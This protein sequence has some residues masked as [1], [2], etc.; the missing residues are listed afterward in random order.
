MPVLAYLITFHTYGSW[1]K[2]NVRG[3]VDRDH[4]ARGEPF[5]PPNVLQ[6]KYERGRMTGDG[7]RISPEQRFVIDHATRGVCEHRAWTLH[8]INIRTTHVHVVVTS[9]DRPEKVMGDMKAW[10]TR[11]LR[12]SGVVSAQN[13]MW[14]RHGSTRYLWDEVSVERAVDY[15][16]RRQGAPLPMREIQ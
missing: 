6:E 7:V 5:V 11:R 10:C 8:A 3:S 1:L 15:V 13:R 12:E 4:N 14:S 16:L 9:E 2:G